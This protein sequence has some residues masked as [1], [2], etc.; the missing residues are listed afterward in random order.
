MDRRTRRY[1][2]RHGRVRAAGID[3]NSRSSLPIGPICRR[4]SK[5]RTDLCRGSRSAPSGTCRLRREVDTPPGRGEGNEH[6]PIEP[7]KPPTDAMKLTT[8]SLIEDASLSLSR[9][10]PQT[11]RGTRSPPAFWQE[12]AP[13]FEPTR[14]ELEG[15]RTRPVPFPV[16]SGARV[17]LFRPICVDENSPSCSRG[18][19]VPIVYHHA[20]IRLVRC[21]VIQNQRYSKRG[22]ADGAPELSPPAALLGRRA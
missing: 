3:H 2:F 15:S 5:P 18:A 20:S 8:S 19:S 9:G 6:E 10:E 21:S 4:S 13:T 16:S 17:G 1:H 14:C 22:E 12:S 7:R 11:S